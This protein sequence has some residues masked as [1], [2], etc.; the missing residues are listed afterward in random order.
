MIKHE[1]HVNRTG[2]ATAPM[3]AD[4]LIELARRAPPSPEA[5]VGTLVQVRMAY[6]DASDLL[7]SLPPPASGHG[8]DRAARK[9]GAVLLDK[10]GE[11][12]AFE[13]SGVRLYDLLLSK[14]EAY[15]SW[16][17]GPT[18]EDLEQIRAEELE[19]FHML[20]EI[21]E[22]LGADATA[23]TPSADLHGVIG[24]GLPAAVAD[25]RTSLLQCLEAVLVAELVD[26]DCWE[27]LEDLALAVGEDDLVPHIVHAIEQEREHL[28]KVRLWY[29]AGLSQAATGGLAE[30]FHERA[31]RRDLALE[32]L[33]GGHV[34]IGFERGE[35]REAEAA[36]EARRER[37]RRR[38]QPA[39]SA[40]RSRASTAR[41]GAKKKKKA[42]TA[43]GR[44]AARSIRATKAAGS[45][46]SSRRG[47]KRKKVDRR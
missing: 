3:Q 7:G 17:G 27:S 30:S 11:R 18:R 6:A 37:P 38:R 42:K 35:R 2:I 25:P 28:R 21:L 1:K 19:H 24:H 9:G 31:Q 23:V 47:G 41:A 13:R 4:V 29:A 32:A 20:K 26:S 16:D 5:D 8:A 10:L 43:R 36:G 45:A 34:E 22:E 15:G 33:A 14:L 44:P 40:T 39:R 12:L 46:T